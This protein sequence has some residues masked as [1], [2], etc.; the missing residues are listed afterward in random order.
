MVLSTAG[1]LLAG[2]VIFGHDL[3]SYVSSSAHSIQL[4]V[5]DSVPIEF[6][7]RRARD[8][9]GDIVPEM[10]ANIKLIAQQEV[11]IAS[12]KD[13]IDTSGKQISDER[14]RV[15][16]LRDDLA[17]DQTSFAIGQFT[18]SRDQLKE[19]LG[20]RFD[21][22]KEAE[23][24]LSGKQ[25]LLTNREKSLEAAEQALEKTRSQKSL[26]ESQIAALDA[27]NQ[28]VKAASIGSNFQLDNSK[29]AQSQ[30]L[31]SDIKKQLDVAERV[32]A[33]ESKFVQP[34]QI[35]AVSDKDLLKQVDEH[36]ASTAPTSTPQQTAQR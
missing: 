1:T 28:L 14:V 5:K 11:E 23:V 21:D 27:Q 8:L 24:I 35:D 10:Q 2:G 6:Q 34:I 22:L 3:Y 25:R 18:Y 36:L 20:R 13:D 31:I 17:S 16:R 19:D 15:V 33:H 29:L 7:L 32:L 30:E 4:A 9:V 12:L 26:L